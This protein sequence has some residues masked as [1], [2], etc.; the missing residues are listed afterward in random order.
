MRSCLP[1]TGSTVERRRPS[2]TRRCPRRSQSREKV[3]RPSQR[4]DTT[5]DDGPDPR[6]TPQIV[7]I[8]QRYHVPATFFMM[9]SQVVRHPDIVKMVARDGFQIGNHTFTHPDLTSLPGW[10]RSLQI[11]L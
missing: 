6:Y 7:A 8:L 4:L 1:A 3:M 2:G 11:S 10:E 5:F 9:G